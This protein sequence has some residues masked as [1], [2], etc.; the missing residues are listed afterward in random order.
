MNYCEFCENDT[1]QRMYDW[2]GSDVCESC[3]DTICLDCDQRIDEDGYCECVVYED[4][5]VNY[6]EYRKHD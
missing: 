3:M 5:S 6:V 1:D 2:K 4:D